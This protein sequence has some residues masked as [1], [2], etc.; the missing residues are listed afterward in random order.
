M[1][2]ITFLLGSNSSR[3]IGI[4]YRL[5]DGTLTAQTGRSRSWS[6]SH[7]ERAWACQDVIYCWPTSGKEKPRRKKPASYHR[8]RL[9]SIS[10]SSSFPLLPSPLLFHSSYPSSLFSYLLPFLF[11]FKRRNLDHPEWVKQ[12]ANDDEPLTMYYFLENRQ[13]KQATF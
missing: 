13:V 6:S 3:D 10:F 12:N 4:G 1:A 2:D 5:G 11:F 7:W 9:D 8:S